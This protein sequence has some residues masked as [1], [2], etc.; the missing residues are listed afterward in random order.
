MTS[1][2]RESAIDHSSPDFELFPC[3]IYLTHLKTNIH[4][5]KH[6]TP[7]GGIIEMNDL[8]SS[9]Q[10]QKNGREAYLYPLE[11]HENAIEFLHEC[12]DLPRCNVMDDSI[13]KLETRLA[14]LRLRDWRKLQ[15]EGAA[16]WTRR[17]S[18][19]SRG[20]RELRSKKVFLAPLT[21]FQVYVSIASHA[22]L[23]AHYTASARH[24]SL[25]L[26]L[27]S[28]GDSLRLHAHLAHGA[29]I[30]VSAG[31]RLTFAIGLGDFD[32]VA[33]DEGEAIVAASRL[34]T[35]ARERAEVQLEAARPTS[36]RL[37][38]NHP[39]DGAGAGLALE[40]GVHAVDATAGAADPAVHCVEL[41]FHL[42]V[43]GAS[44]LDGLHCGRAI[45][46]LVA[47]R[48]VAL[49]AD[50][51]AQWVGDVL[52]LRID[53]LGFGDA[54]AAVELCGPEPVDHP[55]LLYLPSPHEAWRPRVVSFERCLGVSGDNTNLSS[56][57]QVALMGRHPPGVA[58]GCC[59]C[60]WRMIGL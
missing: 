25:Y 49:A 4:L 33:L 9:I 16:W 57:R 60:C 44:G 7:S 26:R 32:A 5:P 41:L 43:D 29:N 51:R 27:D 48:L 24:G 2:Y 55:L 50:R 18:R 19:L 11:I 52:A 46:A 10:R 22:V 3:F 30:R 35:L 53:R 13:V 17:K 14:N 34:A 28:S 8:P 39:A 59:F 6:L 40:S 31:E 38:R 21:F 20:L 58:H 37:A 54:A 56:G 45:R 47:W 12:Q 36:C 23:P 42:D 15:V 1:G